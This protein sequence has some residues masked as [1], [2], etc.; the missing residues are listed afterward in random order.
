[1]GSG[2]DLP[3]ESKAENIKAMVETA[4]KYGR[5]TEETACVTESEL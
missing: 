4:H 2:D 1:M 3:R 5:Y